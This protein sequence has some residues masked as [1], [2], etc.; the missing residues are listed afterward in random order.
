MVFRKKVAIKLFKRSIIIE[1]VGNK[2]NE[3]AAAN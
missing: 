1:K 2:N 3:A